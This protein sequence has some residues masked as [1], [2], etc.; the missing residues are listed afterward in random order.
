MT[1]TD[2][3]GARSEPS[4]APKLLVVGLGASAGGIQALRTFFSHVPADSGSA[5][6]VILHLSPDHDSK[7]AEVL[8]TSTSIP[9][10]QVT[11]PVPIEP[12]HV[13]V[14]P[15]NRRLEI[16]DGMLTLSEMTQREHRRSPVD[17]FFRALADA[18]G[19]RSVC[20]ILS[21]TG[22]NGSAGLKRVKEYGGLVL[23][24][25]PD[26]AAYNDMPNN[27]IA[28]GLVDIVLPAAE[29]PAR[30][31]EYYGRLRTNVAPAPGMDTTD[32]TDA[33]REVMTL[34]RVRT[35]HDF[36]NY[37]SGTLLRRLQRRLNVV[38][39][40]TVSEYARLIREEPAEAVLLMKDLL[41][42]VTHFFRDPD[43]FTLLEERVIPRLFE[44]KRADDQIRVWVPA[45]ATGEE[46]YSVAMLLAEH[47]E[48]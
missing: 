15:P 31:A 38:G 9:V 29:M 25:S 3:P 37:K 48:A 17:I 40:S 30:I 21:G 41:I 20:A 28:T 11:H 32:E 16:T 14:V 46:A 44:G 6:V 24:Q 4:T 42:S 34:L 5:Y 45:C 8:Q 2:P 12:N 33:L 13:Y 27:A 26:E 23:A 36:A 35:G 1:D 22:P 39:L 43:A 7:L 47:A 18:Y 19:A 10:T